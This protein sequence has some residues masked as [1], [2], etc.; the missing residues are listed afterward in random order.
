MLVTPHPEPKKEADIGQICRDTTGTRYATRPPQRFKGY[1][2]NTVGATAVPLEDI[3]ADADSVRLRAEAGD[4]RWLGLG[5]DTP[6]TA[7]DGELLLTTDDVLVL[8]N[9]GHDELYELRFIGAGGV[10][11]LHAHFYRVR[12]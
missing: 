12:A 7:T 4:V 6:P 8:E 3:P 10:S 1:S 5:D 9:I 2:K 11:T